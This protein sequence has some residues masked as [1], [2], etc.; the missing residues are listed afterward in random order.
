MAITGGVGD[1]RRSVCGVKV[2]SS[3][4][5]GAPVCVCYCVCVGGSI[6]C[7]HAFVY[8]CVRVCVRVRVPRVCL[9]VYYDV[10]ECVCV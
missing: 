8:V 3:Y 2:M 7:V 4:R 9:C 1:A 10:C 5:S 6:M